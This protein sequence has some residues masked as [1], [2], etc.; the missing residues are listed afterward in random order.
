MNFEICSQLFVAL[1]LISVISDIH[2]KHVIHGNLRSDLL[3]LDEN[4]LLTVH[5]FCQSIPKLLTFT[6]I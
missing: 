2:S 4:L 1:Q 5:G 6:R 3:S